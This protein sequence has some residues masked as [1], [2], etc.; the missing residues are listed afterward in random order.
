MNGYAVRT[1]AFAVTYGTIFWASNQSFGPY[2]FLLPPIAAGALWMVAQTRFGLRR[3]DVI[4]LATTAAVAAT[5]VGSGLLM[6]LTAAVWAVLP[7]LLF[8]TL[9]Q[10]W[11]PGYWLGHGDRF[12]RSRS[13]FA[14][15]TGAAALTSAAG[16]VLHEIVFPGTG[17]TGSLIELLRDTVL[18]TLL[19]LATRAVRRSRHPETG[20]SNG[21]GGSGG[22][23]SGGPGS[24]GPGRAL[25]VVR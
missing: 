25:T 15:L 7:P 21:P 3:F 10:R 5:L 20:G 24:G 17:L 19:T 2:L 18:I 13:S 14:K 6:S 1:A 16:A 9:L 22:P 12:R 11:L 8:A 4:A 23:G